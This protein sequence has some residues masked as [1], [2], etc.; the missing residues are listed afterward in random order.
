[1]HSGLSILG[2]AI[3]VRQCLISP[4]PTKSNTRAARASGFRWLLNDIG[5]RRHLDKIADS[6]YLD[7]V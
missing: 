5:D 2:F 7:N 1:M 3:V 6:R 4:F